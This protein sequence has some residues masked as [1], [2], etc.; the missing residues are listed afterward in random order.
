MVKPG[1]RSIKTLKIMPAMTLALGS[2]PSIARAD[3][4]RQHQSF[5]RL[6]L[7]GG[8]AAMMGGAYTALSND[9]SG[10]FYNPAG[11]VQGTQN[12]VSLNTWSTNRS[13]VVFKEAVRG[14]DFTETSNTLFGGFAGGVFHKKW[15]TLGYVIATLDKRNINQDDY[16][17]DISSEEGQARDFT[18]IHQES[19]SYDLFGAS[20]AFSLG[21]SWSI[22]L[23][24]F[25]YDR[26]IEA[27]DY[28]QVTFNGGQV[29]VQ[30]SK[31]RVSNQGFHGNAGLQY[32]GDDISLG[33]SVRIGEPVLNKGSLNFNS[34]TH[35]V[36][37][38][39][40]DVVN[41][42]SDDYEADTEIIP[43]IYRLG[44]AFHPA[45][46]FLVSTDL[47]YSSPVKVDNG[48]PDRLGTWN[49]AL[50]LETGF[51]NWR[52]MLGVFTNNSTF[53]EIQSDG[54]NQTAHL[55][56][57]GKTIGTSIITKSFDLHLGFV[58][59]DGRGTAQIV[60]GATANQ[61][62][63]ATTENILLSWTF[64]L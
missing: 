32:R 23:A 14:Q 1:S 25:Y 45:P 19:N 48:S 42:S 3:L 58:R 47:T 55:D 35:A 21:K 64:K 9:P 18:R 4:A 2:L 56:Y 20:V 7:P 10:L 57:L 54:A 60:A 41:Y 59:Q 12:Q 6:V 51:T 16:F 29:L 5:D 31:V 40:P 62:V 53:P 22:G 61:R 24:S 49:Y 30:E 38:T 15:I 36:A 37:N 11:I 26:S 8:R 52:L 44:L 63:E 34:V 39:V 28:Q 46:G 43:T 13:E 50:G 33:A 17:Y 27:M